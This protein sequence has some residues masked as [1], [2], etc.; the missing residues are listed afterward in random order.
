[1]LSSRCSTEVN[2][3]AIVST[4]L[5]WFTDSSKWQV[6]KW[7]QGLLFALHSQSSVTNSLRKPHPLLRSQPSTESRHHPNKCLRCFKGWSPQQMSLH[8]S[9]PV[10]NVHIQ[11]VITWLAIYRMCIVLVIDQNQQQKQEWREDLCGGVMGVC[12]W[13]YWPCNPGW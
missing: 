13:L 7:G 10:E 6:S 4:Y 5:P 11:P 3:L 1:M 12:C 8:M 9:N 2:G